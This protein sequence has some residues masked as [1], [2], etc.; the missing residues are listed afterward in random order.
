M[1]EIRPGANIHGIGPDTDP[2][3]APPVSID[4]AAWGTPHMHYE[5]V[6]GIVMSINTQTVGKAALLRAIR[7]LTGLAQL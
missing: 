2:T 6:E 5:D 4:P 7:F 1:G 3:A